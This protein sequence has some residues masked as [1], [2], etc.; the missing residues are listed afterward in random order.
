MPIHRMSVDTANLPE[1]NR[2]IAPVLH[3]ASSSKSIPRFCERC[4]RFRVPLWLLFMALLACVSIAVSVPA[5][6]I[7]YSRSIVATD[8]FAENYRFLALYTID[9]EVV[10]IIKSL[11]ASLMQTA[12]YVRTSEMTSGSQAITWACFVCI[13]QPHSSIVFRS[14]TWTLVGWVCRKLYCNIKRGTIILE[15]PIPKP[16]MWGRRGTYSNQ[17]DR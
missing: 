16:G 11:S 9:D 17:I 8:L 5:Y 14:E 13:K 7:P 15:L 3:S 1:I 6:F 2:Y 12:E 10:N 4:V